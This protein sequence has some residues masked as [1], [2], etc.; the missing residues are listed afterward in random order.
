M[1]KKRNK[2][3]K[4][5]EYFDCDKR[6]CP[7]FK[8]ADYRCWMKSGTIRHDENCRDENYYD[9]KDGIWLEKIEACIKCD[10]LKLNM[11]EKNLSDIA[12]AASKKFS[13]YKQKIQ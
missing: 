1:I 6:S 8:S 11:K 10:V 2:R 5:W 9:E 4:C 7:S 3:V 12:S 13:K